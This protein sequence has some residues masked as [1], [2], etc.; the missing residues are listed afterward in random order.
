VVIVVI[1]AARPFRHTA[2][3]PEITSVACRPSGACV[4]VGWYKDEAGSYQA[5]VMTQGP[6]GWSRARQVTL[7]GNARIEKQNAYL[8]SVAC[9]SALSCVAFGRYIDRSGSNQ[10]MVVDYAVGVLGTAREVALPANA[11]TR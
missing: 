11:A 9:A 10:S 3:G 2:S 4:A 8:E 5:M 1:A 6:G 7:P